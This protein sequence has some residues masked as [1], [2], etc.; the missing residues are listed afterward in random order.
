[1]KKFS[2]ILLTISVLCFLRLVLAHWMTLRFLIP[3]TNWEHGA[4]MVVLTITLFVGS[5]SLMLYYGDKESENE[6]EKKVWKLY[7]SETEY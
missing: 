5:V 7:L 3:S 4:L 1:M 6:K 2:F